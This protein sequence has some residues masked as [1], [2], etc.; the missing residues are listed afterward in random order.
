MKKKIKLFVTIYLIFLCLGAISCEDCGPF[1]DSFKVTDLDWK[2]Y[3]GIYTET[4]NNDL[5]LLIVVVLVPNS[6]GS[7]LLFS[8]ST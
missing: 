4:P 1:P 6:N 3:E 7:A 5:L 2:I 8:K